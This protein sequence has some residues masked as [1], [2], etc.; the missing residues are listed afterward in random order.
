MH[1]H[2]KLNTRMSLSLHIDEDRRGMPAAGAPRRYRMMVHEACYAR[3]A[4]LKYSADEDLI[5]YD[6]SLI[7]RA[8]A[9]RG[10]RLWERLAH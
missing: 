4:P 5:G 3:F 8:D 9:S 6:A 10:M 7:P 2:E 1:P